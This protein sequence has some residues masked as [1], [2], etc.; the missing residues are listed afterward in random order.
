MTYLGFLYLS[1]GEYLKMTGITNNKTV[2][3]VVWATLV[4][5]IVYALYDDIKSIGYIAVGA[6]FALI[7]ERL[8]RMS[9]EESR[10]VGR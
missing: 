5:A 10:S 6:S 4:A 8:R 7:S 1:S 9:T 2:L 3:R